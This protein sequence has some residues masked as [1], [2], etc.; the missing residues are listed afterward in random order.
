MLLLLLGSPLSLGRHTWNESKKE[1]Q[2][3]DH[4]QIVV[5]ELFLKNLQARQRSTGFQKNSV[6]CRL[7]MRSCLVC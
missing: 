4:D 3:Q 2:L 5:D 6:Y 1:P 7:G